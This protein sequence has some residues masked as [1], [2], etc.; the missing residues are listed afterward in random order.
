MQ[1]G[2][3]GRPKGCRKRHEGFLKQIGVLDH[4]ALEGL[5]NHAPLSQFLRDHIAENELVSRKNNSTGD[6]FQRPRLVENGN[7]RVFRN[8]FAALERSEIE[9]AHIRKPPG[10][11]LPGGGRK[12]LELL[13]GGTLLLLK[14]IGELAFRRRT[15]EDRSRFCYVML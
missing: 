9:Q 13:P 3:F 1:S 11:I 7:T 8:F 15:G 4:S 6:F 12:R 5:K 14:P 2:K 10:L